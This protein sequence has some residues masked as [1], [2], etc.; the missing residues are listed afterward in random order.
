MKQFL[1]SRK[2]KI[3][4]IILAAVV[5]MPSI[6]FASS[7]A[8]DIGLAI[9]SIFARL[10]GMAGVALNLAVNHLVIGFG[11]KMALG[12]GAS[13][14]NAWTIIRDVINICFIFGLV[15]IGFK[16]ILDN[17]SQ[18]RKMLP[19]LIIAALLINFS[20]FFT[21]VIIDVTNVAAVEIFE[22]A[23]SQ[24]AAGVPAGGSVETAEQVENATNVG[25]S[26]AY[27][28]ILGLKA[29]ISPSRNQP[30]DEDN[31]LKLIGSACT[32]EKKLTPE[33]L[34]G[35]TSDIFVFFMVASIFM[36]VAT[37][38]FLAGAFLI[39]VR[40]ISLIILMILSPLMF[41][42]MALPLSG[43]KKISS[44]WWNA[45][46][47]SAFM[48]PAYF[49]FLY[50]GLAV[51]S[52]TQLDGGAG[53]NM[54]RA[55]QGEYAAMVGILN[56]IIVAAFM[57]FA[58]TTARK[59]AKSG[60]SMTLSMADNARRRGQRLIMVG[61]AGGAAWGMRNT[62]GRQADKASNSERLR[63]LAASNNKLYAWAGRQA[64]NRTRSA[65]DSS[66]D[67]RNSS[68]ATGAVGA[69]GGKA[70]DELGKG[71]KKGYASNKK[72]RDKERE[73]FAESLGTVDVGLKK[74]KYG[75]IERHESGEFKGEAIYDNKEVES[76]IRS[77]TADERA[78]LRKVES[79]YADVSGSFADHNNNGGTLTEAEFNARKKEMQEKT[80]KAKDNL[81]KATEIAEAS[82]EYSRQLNYKEAMA[83]VDRLNGAIADG[84]T[85]GAAV[86][87]AVVAGPTLAIG[88]A[89]AATVAG[90]VALN[91]GGAAIGAASTAAG[92]AAGAAGGLGTTVAGATAGGA[93]LKRWVSNKDSKGSLDKK[94]GSDGTKAK[95]AQKKRDEL[96]I[97]SDQVKESTDTPKDAGDKEGE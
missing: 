67:L 24:D 82:V 74:D 7:W 6:T 44:D 27:M 25:I 17:A 1:Y 33:M 73:K 83:S 54:F 57:L 63:N 76:Q 19:P 64:L 46:L 55:T 70:T 28:Q 38:A 86:L 79:D 34:V 65:A 30:D 89:K 87:G 68:I 51:G 9:F 61:A 4:V 16:V 58:V 10:A 35:C 14:E 92:A 78:A 49:L 71:Q 69:F 66:F 97:I 62:V 23:L 95:K 12:F 41:L 60:S 26:G 20:L 45:F 52:R 80:K 50:I 22:M 8:L 77:K 91:V 59:M 15:Y 48:A 42:S 29:L 37:Y 72:D 84:V 88:V 2:R 81:Q 43:T 13:V 32:E 11:G 47:S 94:Y 18:A 40:F 85:A 31:Y 39:V 5:L 75:N 3:Y 53:V 96:K 93:G 56:L 21:K 36:L 90:S